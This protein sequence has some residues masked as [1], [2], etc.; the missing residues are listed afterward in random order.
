MY[1]EAR[2]SSIK[3]H[4]SVAVLAATSHNTLCIIYINRALLKIFRIVRNEVNVKCCCYVIYLILELVALFSYSRSWNKPVP[5]LLPSSQYV[6][7]QY[8][9]RL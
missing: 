1:L 4:E 6:Y 9:S 2:I 8:F 3:I 5:G 7:E